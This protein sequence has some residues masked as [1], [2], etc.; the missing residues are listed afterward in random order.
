MTSSSHDAIPYFDTLFEQMQQDSVLGQAFSKH[1]HWGYWSEPEHAELTLASFLNAADNMTLQHFNAANINH[2][3]S[4]LDTGCGFGGSLALLNEHYQHMELHG[5][6]IDARQIA[7]A[8]ATVLAKP[9]SGNSL[10]FKVGDACC[11][12]YP[13]NYFDNV[14]AVE[15]IFHFPSRSRYFQQVHRVLKPGGRLIISDFLVNSATSLI[16]A[17]FC[18]PY[19]G[20]M[21]KYYGELGEP[22]TLAKYQK[23]ADATGLT[24]TNNIN[25]TKGTLPTYRFLEQH[26]NA[27]GIE[28]K[29]MTRLYRFQHLVS[30]LDFHRYSILTF[31]KT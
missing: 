4:I 24:L 29:E 15:C 21:K 3:Q 23:L 17:C 26:I 1:V 28:A 30:R 2:H 25:I 18:L 13:D 5:I 22:M 14:L 7:R 10:A 20:L 19:L 12:D 8:E 27:T 16:F 11:L 9:G 31:D 6:N